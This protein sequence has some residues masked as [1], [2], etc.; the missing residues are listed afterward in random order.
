MEEPNVPKRKVLWSET[1][2]E[3]FGHDGMISSKSEAFNPKNTL[4]AVIDGGGSLILWG[5]FALSGTG[6]QSE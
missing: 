5:W 4:S 3:L 6:T 1:K 2:I